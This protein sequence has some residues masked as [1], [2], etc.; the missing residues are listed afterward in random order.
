MDKEFVALSIVFLILGVVGILLF[1]SIMPPYFSLSPVMTPAGDGCYCLISSPEPGAAQSTSSILLAL[2]V[3]FFPMGLMKGGLPSFKRAA[4]PAGPANL[5]AAKVPSPL[6]IGSGSYFAFGIVLLLVGVDAL[7]VPGYLVF[8][9]V[10]YV[11]AGILLTA[12]GAISSFWGLR[13]R[14]Q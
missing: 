1:S 10:Y 2:G 9:N 6:P 5:P 14:N 4:P 8:Q 11:I 7:L 12:A 3:M 13:R